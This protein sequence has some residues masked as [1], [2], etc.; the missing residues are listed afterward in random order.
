MVENHRKTIGK[1]WF[2]GGLMGFNQQNAAF[3]GI[4]PLVNVHKK[5]LKMAQSK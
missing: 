3:N 4:Y 1:W 5:L 2:N